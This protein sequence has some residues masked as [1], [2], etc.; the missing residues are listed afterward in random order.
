MLN[1][2]KCLGIP[3][4]NSPCNQW[5]QSIVFHSKVNLPEIWRL[6][7]DPHC[8]TKAAPLDFH[9]PAA[10]FFV[11]RYM[12]FH[13]WDA[14]FTVFE[15]VIPPPYS[16]SSPASVWA[17]PPSRSLSASG[18]P[19]YPFACADNGLPIR[20][21]AP[22]CHFSNANLPLWI[23]SIKPMLR[24]GANTSAKYVV[25]AGTSAWFTRNYLA[26]TGT[27]KRYP[28]RYT[29]VS[30]KDRTGQLWPTPNPPKRAQR[31]CILWQRSPKR[32]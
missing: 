25:G 8:P 13:A 28:R 16:T 31:L 17:W 9:V 22:R 24:S 29:Y 18:S 1:C 3:C 12:D 5:L 14:L 30:R 2:V 27:C 10:L 26:V 6:P 11:P 23:R 21:C 15:A 4:S 20:H 7:L 19:I 32:T